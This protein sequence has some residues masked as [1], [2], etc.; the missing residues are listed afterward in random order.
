MTTR[1]IIATLGIAALVAA[2]IACSNGEAATMSESGAEQTAP[3]VQAPV[4]QPPAQTAAQPAQAVQAPATQPPAQAA[5]RAAAP[6][7]PATAPV[8]PQSGGGAAAAALQVPTSNTGIWVTGQANIS[9]E[10]DLVLLNVGV[11][12][13]A[14]TVAEARGQAAQAMDAIITA[15]RAHGL[16]DDDVQTRSFNIWPRYEYPEVTSGGTSTRRQT[17]VGYTV[18]NTATIKIRD[19]DAVGAI[20]DDVAEAGGRRNADRRHQLQ[21]RGP[22]AVH[23]PAP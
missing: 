19:V 18:N 5:A 4:A 8:Q 23:D 22:Q 16:G 9:V 3:A 1:G 7:G 20:I 6:A 2:G 21:H 17:L 14:E 11:E 15:V 13:M 10:P 12:T